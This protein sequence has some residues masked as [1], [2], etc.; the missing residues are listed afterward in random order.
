M[1]IQQQRDISR[2]L[3][4]LNHAKE[5]RNISK[6]CR[7]FGVSREIFYRWKRALDS[8]RFWVSK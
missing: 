6:T 2:K 3:R 7:Y 5:T 4:I 8:K 1:T